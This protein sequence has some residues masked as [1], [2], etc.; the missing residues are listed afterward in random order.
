MQAIGFGTNTVDTTDYTKFQVAKPGQFPDM[1][2][3][4]KGASK[5]AGAS[6]AQSFYGVPLPGF[7]R[8]GITRGMSI[9]GEA[10]PEAIVPLPD[11]RT[12][13]VKMQGE[14]AKVIVNVDAQGTTVEGDTAGANRL[15]EAIGTAVRQELIKQKRP[16][17]LLA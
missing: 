12:I 1:P 8:G 17:G 14:G 10:G 6:G 7:A 4:G 9:A 13:P 16:G 11:G 15:G 2:G 3:F 5:F